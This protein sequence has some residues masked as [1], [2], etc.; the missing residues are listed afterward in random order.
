MTTARYD[1]RSTKTGMM[2]IP[3]ILLLIVGMYWF[4][5]YRVAALAKFSE[6]P[7]A[8]NTAKVYEQ[9][10]PT[11]TK[12]PSESFIFNVPVIGNQVVTDV[13]VCVVSALGGFDCPGIGNV[14][15]LNINGQWQVV[16]K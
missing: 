1:Y 9:V 7:N 8:A 14:R 13:G 15:A 2:W 10:K 3:G 12:Q 16:E 5:Q 4:N 11:Q 6:S